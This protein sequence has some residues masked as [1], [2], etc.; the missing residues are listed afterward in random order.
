MQAPPAAGWNTA[1][2]L[3]PGSGRLSRA[4]RAEAPER[5]RWP[6]APLWLHARNRLALVPLAAIRARRAGSP[7]SCRRFAGGMQANRPIGSA[8]GIRASRLHWDR[9]QS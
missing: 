8:D 2:L 6:A 3:L 5:A 4:F 9:A 1:S 7:A